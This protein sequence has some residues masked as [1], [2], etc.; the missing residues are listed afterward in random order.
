LITPA[1]TISASA[2]TIAA[3]TRKL[4][5]KLAVPLSVSVVDPCPFSILQV[6]RHSQQNQ[7]ANA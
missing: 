6:R 4:R 5:R 3:N 1:A 7:P 2:V